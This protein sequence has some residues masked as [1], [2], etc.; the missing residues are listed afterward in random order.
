[1][2]EIGSVKNF[3]YQPN[4]YNPKVSTPMPQQN[5]NNLDAEVKELKIE[6]S[7]TRKALIGVSVTSTFIIGGLLFRN[8][9]LAK[10]AKVNADVIKD[11]LKEAIHK[12]KEATKKQNN[13]ACTAKDVANKILDTTII[14]DTLELL[15]DI[16]ILA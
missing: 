10:K 8:H 15:A 13:E 7:K 6:H 3:G 12:L 9:L 4:Y 5:N 1:M 11:K 2:S 14:A 16:A